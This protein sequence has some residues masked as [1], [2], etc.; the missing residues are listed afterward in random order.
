[1][2]LSSSR[3]D[4]AARR[5]VAALARRPEQIRLLELVASLRLPDGWIGAGFVRA[6]VWDE[7][8]GFAGPA[9]FSD[10]DVVYF[11]PADACPARDAALEAALAAAEPGL[12]WSVA[13]Q[14][15]MH[16]R[17][18]DAPYTSTA[19]ALT[20]WP[21]TCTAVAARRGA[22]GI[23]VLAPLGLDDLLALVVRP[24]PH[25]SAHPE[26]CRERVRAKQWLHRWPRLRLEGLD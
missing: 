18:A 5:V 6:A 7:L 24:T 4:T 1:M 11:D 12:P 10:I 19:D 16:L 8:H 13:N 17:H 21:E 15:R 23:E 3:D 20:H 14:A 25:L 22:E 26:I 9:P 2:S